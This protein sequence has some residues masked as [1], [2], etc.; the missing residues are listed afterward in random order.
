MLVF[1]AILTAHALHGVVAG[2]AGGTA[3]LT[4]V[5]VDAAL[6]VHATHVSALTRVH[7]LALHALL[8]QPTLTVR[9]TPRCRQTHHHFVTPP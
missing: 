2:E 3:A 8:C 9:L 5:I 6:C 7:T 4:H 1:L